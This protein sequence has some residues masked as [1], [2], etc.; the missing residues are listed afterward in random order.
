MV[1]LNVRLLW[2]DLDPYEIRNK[3]ISSLLQNY[4]NELVYKPSYNYYFVHIGNL[5]RTHLISQNTLI[6]LQYKVYAFKCQKKQK[7]STY[8]RIN[9]QLLVRIDCNQYCPSVCL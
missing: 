5:F 1:D 2:L 6:V 8:V 4:D 9:A 3:I 7:S